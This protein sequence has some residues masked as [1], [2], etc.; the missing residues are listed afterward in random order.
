MRIAQLALVIMLSLWL[1]A[2]A[3]SGVLFF[4]NDES[5]FAAAIADAALM[6]SEDWSSAGNTAAASVMDPLAPGVANGPFPNGTNPATGLTVQSND[7]STTGSTPQPGAGLFYAPAG[8]EG[9]SGNLQPSNQ[10]SSNLAGNS[11]D[12][13]FA[14]V[15]EARPTAV[16]FSPMYYLLGFNDTGTLAIVV[17]NTNNELIGST[18]LGDVADV[19][20]NEFLGIQTTGGDILGR[21][22]IYAG[23]LDVPGADN[24]AVYAPEPSA[25]ANSVL[26]VT[27]LIA[28][29]RGR[30]RSK[31]RSWISSDGASDARWTDS[32]CA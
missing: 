11:F 8:S 19:L 9:F 4:V 12:M 21:V 3:R 29:A 24:I 7:E 26:A 14:S 17:F 31:L 6:G 23:E 1:P 20:E 27:S 15:G 13:L 22:N 32:L 5:G 18:A 30:S 16:S 10:V 28:L 2:S 25:A